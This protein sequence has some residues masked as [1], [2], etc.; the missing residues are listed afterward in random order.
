[1]ACPLLIVDCGV[2]P[3]AGDRSILSHNPQS[4]RQSAR[5]STIDNRQAAIGNR[6]SALGND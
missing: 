2:P 5:H 3:S 4:N 6:Q 1:V